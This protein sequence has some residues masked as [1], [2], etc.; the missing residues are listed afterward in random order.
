MVEI[1]TGIL[2]L[3]SSVTVALLGFWGA[4]KFKI[5]PNQEKLVAT[6]KDIVAAQETRIE[7]L[8]SLL[9]QQSQEIATLRSEVAQLRALT[10][11]QA[12]MITRLRN[13]KGVE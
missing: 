2:A 3:I 5:G 10:V 6:L 11:E 9:T 13:E 1:S 4:K 7:Q 12:L 8:E